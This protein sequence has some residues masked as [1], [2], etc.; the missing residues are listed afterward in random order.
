MREN[1]IWFGIHPHAPQIQ[2]A[3]SQVFAAVDVAPGDEGFEVL[4]A[5]ARGADEY[6]ICHVPCYAF[7][8]SL[9]DTVR[10]GSYSDRESVILD[11]IK[12][13][14]HSTVRVAFD[15]VSSKEEILRLTVKLG[16]LCAHHELCSEHWLGLD[17]ANEEEVEAVERLLNELVATDRVT[18]EFGYRHQLSQ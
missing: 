14:G 8:L 2:G 5:K 13:S 10:T 18:Y 6:E 12:A 1:G 7:G 9:G 11:R 16:S 4:G 15:D 17:L 3:D